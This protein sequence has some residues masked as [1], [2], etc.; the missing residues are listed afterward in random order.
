MLCVV[1]ALAIACTGRGALVAGRLALCVV[2]LLLFGRGDAWE[3]QRLLGAAQKMGPA[4]LVQAQAMVQMIADAANEPDNAR[5]KT[6]NAF[7]N[8]RIEYRD[9]RDVWGVPDYW[10]TPLESLG[11]GAGDCEDYAIAKY[12]ALIAA[13]TPPARMRLVYVRADLGGSAVAHMVLAYYAE[14]NGEPVI[15]D[16]LISEI[17]PASRRP[18]LAPVFSF[19]AEGL[20]QGVTG[21]SAGDPVARLSRWRD[22]LAKVR[23]EGWW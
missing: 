1:R 17:R 23:A 15:L 20:W 13:G 10:A 9:D 5:L 22:L 7:F 4:T 12:L 14:P 18:D 19:N 3:S 11:K 16:N 21:A 2:V 6:V 8:R